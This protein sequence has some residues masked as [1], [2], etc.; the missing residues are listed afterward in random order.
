MKSSPDLGC[1]LCAWYDANGHATTIRASR[2]HFVYTAHDVLRFSE[3]GS[4][5]QI[6]DLLRSNSAEGFSLVHHLI[7]AQ[8]YR[9]TV[10]GDL[11]PFCFHMLGISESRGQEARR[12]KV[13]SSIEIIR[14]LERALGKR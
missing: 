7:T 14:D 2:L 5:E 4:A 6:C 11:E 3:A 10:A 9:C 12:L 13:H 1:C 8:L